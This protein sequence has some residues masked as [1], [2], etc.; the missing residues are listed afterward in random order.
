MK[1]NS[2]SVRKLI[3]AHILF[4]LVI[5]FFWSVLGLPWEIIYIFDVLVLIEF[6][7]AL[8]S[9]QP[10][11]RRTKAWIIVPFMAAYV[12][13]LLLTQLF[14]F[15]SPIAAVMAFR[16]QFRFYL[17]F[18]ACAVI[19]TKKSI[20]KILK[21]L[22]FVQVLN[23][24]L[25][26]YQYFQQGLSQDYLGGMFGIA[27]GA[28]AYSNVYL[29]LVCTY[30]LLQYLGKK[31]NIWPMLLTIGSSLL[32]AALAE[33][34]VFFIEIVIIVLMAVLL[35]NPS[36]RT[37]KTVAFVSV[38]FV[39]SITLLGAIFPEHFA[40]L[41]SLALLTEYTTESIYG[42]NIS[43]LNAFSEIN[44]IFFKNNGLRNLFGYGFGNCENGTD[45]YNRYSH[46]NY[47][48]FTHQITFLETGYV[49][50]L[51]YI[52]F[53]ALIFIFSTKFKKANPENA[54]YY[55]FSQ[56]ISVLC[57]VWMIYD[58]SLRSEAAYMAFFALAIPIAVCNDW[59][60]DL[61][62]KS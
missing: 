44:E 61:Y 46:F 3:T 43:R 11:L 50:I 12:L 62:K 51:F 35:S 48:W 24:M 28:N 55:T 8:G 6:A 53:F 22:L 15:V 40:V 33:L 49:G 27:K 23:L 39:A 25:T 58:Q 42:Y 4:L 17:F 36:A 38:G 14:N 16:K 5:L 9:L 47:S 37:V 26:V 2:N 34:K 32:I 60:K 45:F 59:L 21:I 30:I 57:V 18:C 31:I 41:V 7:W 56:I 29:C 19:L 1:F 10:V 20:D 52:A 54:S 13:Y